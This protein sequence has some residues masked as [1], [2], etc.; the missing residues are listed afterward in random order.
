M[1]DLADR[2]IEAAHKAVAWNDRRVKTY[3]DE[4][5]LFGHHRVTAQETAIAV[6]EVLYEY[7]GESV[8]P[9]PRLI[10]ELKQSGEQ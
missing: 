5:R 8:L 2:M 9:L 4:I 1:T 7:D 6:L 3:A 10:N